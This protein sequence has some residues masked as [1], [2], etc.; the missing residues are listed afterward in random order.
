MP[1]NACFFEKQALDGF[2]YPIIKKKLEIK[3]IM[4]YYTR[5]L[6]RGG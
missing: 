6:R 1:S 2:F 5:L 3:K 4:M